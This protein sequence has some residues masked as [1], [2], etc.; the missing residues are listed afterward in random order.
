MIVENRKRKPLVFRRRREQGN[1]NALFT[2]LRIPLP[3]I[4]R[5]SWEKSAK[6]PLYSQQDIYLA[7]ALSL[8]L[9]RVGVEK[10][11]RLIC[12]YKKQHLQWRGAFWEWWKG[13]GCRLGLTSFPAR[14]ACA[15]LRDIKGL[16]VTDKGL[17]SGD[18]WTVQF[19]CPVPP[20]PGSRLLPGD[21]TMI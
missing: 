19:V 4:Q 20:P 15:G 7:L 14:R 6:K 9:F 10:E 1:T 8:H 17:W 11:Q 13:S 21:D 2:H 5:A 12:I 3:H 18:G 16:A